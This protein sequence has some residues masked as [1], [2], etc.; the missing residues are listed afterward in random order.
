MP[1][2]KSTH[3]E[4]SGQGRSGTEEQK[5]EV[6]ISVEDLW[7]R[8]ASHVPLNVP[9]PIVVLGEAAI[10]QALLSKGIPAERLVFID[11]DKATCERFRASFPG[12]R[13]IV[14]EPFSQKKGILSQGLEPIAAILSTSR[15]PG[16]YFLPIKDR[17]EFLTNT[18]ALL[19]PGSP[20]IQADSPADF[21]GATVPDSWLDMSLEAVQTRQPRNLFDLTTN[22][23]HV[24]GLIEDWHIK[25]CRAPDP[26]NAVAESLL[27]R[28]QKKGYAE[29]A[30]RSTSEGNI[31]SENT[32][33]SF[34][35]AATSPA[36]PSSLPPKPTR[37]W[38]ADFR[39]KS[40]TEKGDA[41]IKFIEDEYGAFF[42]EYRD[43]MRDYIR[44]V[45]PKLHAAIKNFG[46]SNLPTRFQMPSRDDKLK[47]RL[48]R[49]AAGA[50]ERMPKS[51][52][53]SVR[54][55]LDRLEGKKGPK[56]IN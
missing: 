3:T 52:K 36:S 33:S 4:K 49:A 29:Q 7:S 10:G 5:S 37:Y 21:G 43:Q 38:S 20:F 32:K 53:R 56:S 6:F 9:G 30:E 13:T 48:K 55:K 31:D 8:M 18:L 41:L 2:E 54:G 11:P 34:K 24:I 19:V 40:K 22:T 50:Y 28:D 15:F 27:Q 42:E 1:V 23:S 25:V 45:D 26:K 39:G 51:E 12:S 35:S 16:P 14:A 47:A 44:S 46:F 17:I